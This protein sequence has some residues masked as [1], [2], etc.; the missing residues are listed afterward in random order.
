MFH[1]DSVGEKPK[2]PMAGMEVSYLGGGDG[3]GLEK[4]GI[5]IYYF[6]FS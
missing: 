6:V 3:H 4:I 1:P 2:L 5:L